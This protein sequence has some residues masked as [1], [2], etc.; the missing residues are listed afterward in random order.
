M[1]IIGFIGLILA[2]GSLIYLSVKGMNPFL[3]AL[4]ATL[5]VVIT[6]QLNVFTAFTVTYATEMSNFIRNFFLMFGFGTAF[7]RFM[8]KSGSSEAVADTLF[9]I[10]GAKFAPLT[11]LIVTWIMAMGG[12][13]AVIIIFSIYPIADPLFRKA[14]ITKALLPA[15]FLNGAVVATFPFPGNPSMTNAVLTMT[16]LGTTAHSAPIMGIIVG[17]VALVATGIYTMVMSGVE[18][19]KGN[20]YVAL[21]EGAAKGWTQSVETTG[22]KNLPPFWSSILPLLT[23]IVNMFILRNFLTTVQS[24]ITALAIATILCGILNFNSLKGKF[25][26][27]FTEGYWSSITP[28]MLMAGVTAFGTVVGSSPAFQIFVNFANSISE[29]F[30]PYISA[31]IAVNIV[32]AV[33]GTALGGL[34][35]FANIL[36]PEYLGMAINPDALHRIAVVA[37]T[38]I[39]TLPHNATFIIYCAVCGVKISTA[40]KHVFLINVLLP[41]VMTAL[42][43]VLALNGIV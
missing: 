11:C 30:H 34:T 17:V 14:N 29:A 5:V 1:E 43:I 7:G 37:S 6:S 38:G 9:R 19:R 27:N 13:S 18:A 36:L 35:V 32:A 39:D 12:I 41:I 31:A 25:L 22:E 33:T 10:F 20:G 2:V 26:E 15:I 28:M 40:Y 24:I 23:V 3:A 21:Q 42:C 4:V 8:D 16:D